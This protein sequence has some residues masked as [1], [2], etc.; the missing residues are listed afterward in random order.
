MK[1]AERFVRALE[2]VEESHSPD[3]LVQ[4]F[5]DDAELLRLNSD[6]PYRGR[7]GARTFWNEYL[8]LFREIRSHFIKVMEYGNTVVLEWHASGQFETGGPV[9]YRGVS[10]VEFQGDLVRRFRTYYDSAAFT[11][12][13]A[14]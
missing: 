13:T 12:P 7:M 2:Q 10:V 6:E 4:L 9:Q 8:S 5:T 1:Q 14:A 3:P 11:Q